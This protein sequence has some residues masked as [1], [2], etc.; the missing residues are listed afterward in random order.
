MTE[1]NILLD[2]L[3]EEAHLSHAGFAARINELGR[4]VTLAAAGLDRSRGDRI[5]DAP[6]PQVLDRAAAFWRS[7]A[8]SATGS[9]ERSAV[10]SGPAAIAPVFEWENPPDDLDVSSQ[11]GHRI[12]TPAD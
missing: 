3:I 1:P 7:E 5:S 12:V 8:R 11:R 2:A 6:L 4:P 10:V 9:A